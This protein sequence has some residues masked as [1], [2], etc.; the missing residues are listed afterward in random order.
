[1]INNQLLSLNGRKTIRMKH[2]FR[3]ECGN[4]SLA[5]ICSKCGKDTQQPKPPKFSLEDKYA[6]YRRQ[7]KKE[8]L[9]KKKLL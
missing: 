4:Y 2:M 6:D 8:E 5:K 1:M 7:T 9:K 3:C